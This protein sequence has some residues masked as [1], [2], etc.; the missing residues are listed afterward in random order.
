MEYAR[1]FGR[2]TGRTINMLDQDSI[3]GGE[4]AKLYDI[5]QFPAII[6]FRDDGSLVQTWTER[7]KWPTISELSYYS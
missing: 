2:Q 5:M 3:E 6:A 7:D 1:E 4:M